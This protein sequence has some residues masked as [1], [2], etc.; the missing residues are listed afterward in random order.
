MHTNMLDYS[1]LDLLSQTVQYTHTHTPGLQK[2]N[3]IVISVLAMHGPMRLG[4]RLPQ[5]LFLPGTLCTRKINRTRIS[6]IRHHRTNGAR[7]LRELSARGKNGRF[8]IKFGMVRGIDM[9]AHPIQGRLER[10]LAA[11]VKHLVA[12]AGR[13]GVPGNKDELG[14]GPVIDRLEIQV[15]DAVSTVIFRHFGYKV[16]VRGIASALFVNDNGFL[17]FNLVRVKTKFFALLQLE[18]LKRAGHFVRYNYTCR[19]CLVNSEC[20]GNKKKE[21]MLERWE[22]K[23]KQLLGK[24]S[25]SREP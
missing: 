22:T 14:S 16:F 3:R 2:V 1:S 15:N 19:L 4:P 11:T 24:E 13:V 21:A 5:F 17:V 6:N 20:E 9:N 10:F 18:L 23:H 12:N 8:Q 25:K 7:R